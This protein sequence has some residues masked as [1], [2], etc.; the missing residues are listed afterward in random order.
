[1]APD[2]TMAPWPGVSS[3]FDAVVPT[4]PESVSGMVVRWKLASASWPVRAGHQVVECVE[5]FLEWEPAGGLDIRD[6][7]AAGAVL[8]GDVHGGAEV[9]PRGR[10][11]ERVS[12]LLRVGRVER[13]D[14]FERLDDGPADQVRVGNLAAAEQGPVLVD[15][16]PVLV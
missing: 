6:H 8:A 13:R 9:D 10:Q 12:V 16:A 3:G 14:L 1:M 7:E 11:A 15:D 5:V 2:A 4:V